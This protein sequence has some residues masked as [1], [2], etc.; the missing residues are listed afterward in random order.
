MVENK[1]LPLIDYCEYPEA[2]MKRR[3]SEFC[4]EM[5]RRRTVRH[6]SDRPVDRSVIEDCLRTASTA[7]SGANQQPWIFIVV[8]DLTVKRRIREAA[9]KE[10]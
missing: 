5:T 4:K 2:E 1:F 8:S 10:I 9:E 6:F 3:A 7:P